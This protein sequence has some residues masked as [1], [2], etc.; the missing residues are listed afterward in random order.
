MC[1]LF[2]QLLIILLLL[3]SPYLSQPKVLCLHCCC[4]CEC[5]NGVNCW[6]REGKWKKRSDTTEVIL[7]ILL[8]SLE[9]KR[10]IYMSNFCEEWCCNCELTGKAWNIRGGLRGCLFPIV[11]YVLQSL[12]RKNENMLLI[13]LFFRHQCTRSGYD[14]VRTRAWKKF[15]CAL[16]MLKFITALCVCV[17]M[18]ACVLWTRSEVTWCCA[19]QLD[20]THVKHLQRA[21]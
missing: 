13:I 6:I 1:F 3:Y 9:K 8:Y 2:K 5:I 19:L 21:L 7:V 4:V 20:G 17:C 14:T 16:G 12:F 15:N 10:W 18:R 11:L